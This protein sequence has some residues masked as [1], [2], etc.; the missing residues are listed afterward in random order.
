MIPAV[1]V[2]ALA[3]TGTPNVDA[4][5]ESAM[6]DLHVPGVV[7]AIVEGDEPP[8]LKAYGLANVERQTPMSV[9]SRIG[10][11]STTKLI[12]GL[13]ALRLARRGTIALDADIR[14]HLGTVGLD[15]FGG[16]PITLLDLLTHTAGFDERS[17][18][19][20]A[21]S[22]ADRWA[23]SVYLR[24]QLPSRIRPAG[25]VASYSNH[26]FAL[27]GLVMER[28]ARQ[29][30][31]YLA[32]E[33][34]FAPLGMHDSTFAPPQADADAARH[35][36]G[37]MWR[38]DLVPVPEI[39]Y[40]DWPASGAV[41][42]ASDMA[43]LMRALLGDGVWHDALTPRF[44]QHP[45]MPGV[46]AGG[47]VER[48]RGSLVTIQHGGDWQDFFNLVVLIPSRRIG[49]FVAGNNGEAD[50]LGSLVLD[51]ALSDLGLAAQAAAVQT[52]APTASRMVEEQHALDPNLL[53]RY[54]STRH[55][56]AG[57]EK[58]GVLTGDVPELALEQED[59]I[60][61]AGRTATLEAGTTLRRDDGEVW[62]VRAA[63]NGEPAMLFRERTPTTAYERV[64]WIH[65][66]P[67]QRAV[68]VLL[69]VSLITRLAW[70]I[71]R[72]TAPLP[73][74]VIAVHLAFIVGAGVMLTAIDPW[75]FQYGTPLIVRAWLTIPLC[76]LAATL[77]ILVRNRAYGTGALSFAWCAFVYEWNLWVFW[78]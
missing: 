37:Y 23:L 61:V 30:L 22:P 18:G 3:L 10:L 20:S 47:A 77:V 48:R 49:I 39:F 11:Q 55:E 15:D 26:G 50:G 34:V 46:A 9:D 78:K 24:F 4:A 67:V 17:V 25:S 16:R 70:G 27:A 74:A 8:L 40:N 59:D 56:H 45:A 33:L 52:T 58:V 38:G 29:R 72:R 1:V 36:T 28:A 63:G 53:G 73:T 76:A 66:V 6:R 68:L 42:T 32:D 69:L 2:S 21:H 60:R 19:V 51:A 31:E 13:V 14:P 43:A 12:T 64:A 75:T 65:S 5:V 35:V 7:L 57:I 71:W 54:R 62:A 44:R 41:S